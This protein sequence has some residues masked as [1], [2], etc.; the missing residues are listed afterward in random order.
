MAA[1]NYIMASQPSVIKEV[2][3]S[4]K[5]PKEGE[6]DYSALVISF[7]KKCRSNA[8]SDARQ[9]ED[10][11]EYESFRQRYPFDDDTHNYMQTSNPDVRR[12]VMRNFKPPREGE[13][14]YSALLITYCKRCR[15]NMTTWGKGA[16]P[17]QQQQ[18]QQ[19]PNWTPWGGKGWEGKGMEPGW[20]G[21]GIGDGRSIGEG[22]CRFFGP[23]WQTFDHGTLGLD[24]EGDAEPAGAAAAVAAVAAAAAAAAEEDPFQSVLWFLM[25]ES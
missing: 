22:N 5:P 24:A 6:A 10:Q 9:V 15:S 1:Y 12:Y 7:A 2:L 13:A 17:M 3:A 25:V 16:M 11:A 19:Q 14:D 4:F 21:H 18:Q 23:H 8:F 20:Q